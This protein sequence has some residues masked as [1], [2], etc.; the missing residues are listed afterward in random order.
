MKVRKLKSITDRLE[1][2]SREVLEKKKAEVMADIEDSKGEKGRD[3]L[4][5]LRKSSRLRSS[6]ILSTSS[7]SE[8]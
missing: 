8:Q 6:Y 3:I 5:I 2:T 7:P 4:S 1:D